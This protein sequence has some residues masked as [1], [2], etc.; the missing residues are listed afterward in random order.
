MSAISLKYE[1]PHLPCDDFQE[2]FYLGYWHPSADISVTILNP[3][4]DSELAEIKGKN[5]FVL[6]SRSPFQSNGLAHIYA[7]G[8]MPEICLPEEVV[9]FRGYVLEPAIHS[10]SESESIVDYWRNEPE[11]HNGVFS[12]A[13][14]GNKGNDLKLITDA[15]GIATLYYRD[16]LGGILFSTNTRFL[17]TDNDN[18]DYQSARILM[19]CGS[20]Y[21]NRTLTKGVLRV[22][23][24]SEFTFRGGEVATRKWFSSSS[25]ADGKETITI[26][27]LREVEDAFQNSISRCLRLQSS[28]YVL[29]LSSGY[30]SRRILASLHSQ[31]IPFHALTVR[32][33]QKENRDLDGHWSSV[34]A[35]TLGFQHQVVELPTPDE[36][37]KL[38]HIRRT[39]VD[40]HGTEHTWF[41]ALHSHI[42]QKSCLFF[43]GLGGDVFGETGFEKKEYLTID[44]ALKNNRIVQNLINNNL[45]DVLGKWPWPD[46]EEA[47]GELENYLNELPDGSNKSDLAFISMRC[48][49]G[50]GFC[51]QRLIP[52]GH[53]TVYPYFDLDYVEAVLKF[54]PMEKLPPNNIQALCLSEFWPEYYKFP[55]SRNIPSESKANS[56]RVLDEI[57][58][59]CIKKMR[60]E[61]SGNLL[62]YSINTLRYKHILILLF[63]LCNE[64]IAMR[65]KWWIIPLLG[66][67]SRKANAKYHWSNE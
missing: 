39:L 2:E 19:Q 20:V 36:F 28:G 56:S 43:D 12:A 27:G 17:S 55:G 59:A 29:P 26:N 62:N 8:Q 14:I 35:T 5:W 64:S 23:A 46:L 15:F 42:P 53:V 63:S 40:A 13:H 60:T 41:L 10:W 50:T 49:S 48:R 24:G 58:L 65:F 51:F 6:S 4:S 57:G 30:D 34:M 33:L 31:N 22:P 54:N 38:D 52:A 11:R 67:F 25:I 9:V 7:S 61:T 32:V 66:L 21:G 18:F 37:A 1:W 3:P 16:Y 44:D 47:R 45:D